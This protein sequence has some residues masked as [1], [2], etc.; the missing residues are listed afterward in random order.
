MYD[1]FQRGAPSHSVLYRRIARKKLSGRFNRVINF[2]ESLF[3]APPTTLL[4]QIDGASPD[5]EATCY[6]NEGDIHLCV[7]LACCK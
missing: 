3:D 1:I 5:K 4:R 2:I 7:S 6:L